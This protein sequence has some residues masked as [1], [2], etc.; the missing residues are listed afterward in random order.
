MASQSQTPASAGYPTDRDPSLVD[1]MELFFDLIFVALVGQL[2][3]GLDAD[4]TVKTLLVFLAL[5]ASVWWWWVNLTFIVN[6]SADLTRRQ[7]SAAMLV[8]MFAVG[9][10]AVAAPEA[11]GNRAWLFAAGNAMIRLLLLFMWLRRKR[12][13]GGGSWVRIVLYNGLTA[14]LWLVSI[15]VDAPVSYVLWTVAIVIEVVMLVVT[16]G[17]WGAGAMASFNVEHLSERFGLLVIIVL[18]ESVLSIVTTLDG[19]FTLAG[20]VTAATALVI[21]SGLAWS[22]F[23]YSADALRVG[24]EGLVESGQVYTIRDTVAFLPFLLIAGVTMIAG[25]VSVAIHRP[26]HALPVAS[27]ISL[28]GGIAL[29]FIA[30]AVISLRFGASVAR[31]LRWALPAVGLPL[32]LIPV[33]IAVHGELA[34]IAAAVVVVFVVTS[35]ELS[36]RQAAA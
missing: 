17:G 6:L 35:A 2:A 9:T 27:A 3:H 26:Q 31:V 33:A 23:L 11:T 28:G 18:G 21:V 8:A 24:L 7:L 30:N 25:A 12:R 29:F 1:W 5:F 36:A 19:S 13:G 10:I 20:G 4:P 16:T 32:V 34:I 22:F 14:L 15:W